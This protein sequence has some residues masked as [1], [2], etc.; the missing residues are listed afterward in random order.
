[1]SDPVDRLRRKYPGISVKSPIQAHALLDEFLPGIDHFS[2]LEHPSAE[3]FRWLGVCH[4][5]VFNDPEAVAAYERAIGLGSQA[6]RINLAHSLG[7]LDRGDEIG[8]QLEQV[9][10]DQLPIY[11]R[12]L[13]LRVK[14]LNDERNGQLLVALKHTEHAW[15]LIQGIPEFSLLA[16]QLLNQLGILH[17]RVGRAQR[18]LWYL[19]RNLELCRG[20]EKT[21]VHL[22]R[23]HVLNSLGLI[24]EARAEFE[25]MEDV[26]EH[27]AP[28]VQLRNAEIAWA[29]GDAKRAMEEYEKTIHLAQQM[30]QSYEEFQASLDLAVLEA[31][32]LDLDPLRRLG[33][34]QQLISD[35]SDRLMYRFRE[36]LVFAWHDRYSPKHAATELAEVASDFGDMGLL[37]EQGWVHVHRAHALREAGD[38]AACSRALDSL[39]VLTSSLQNPAFLAREWG[40]MPEFLSY[41]SRTHPSI[42][43][44]DEAETGPNGPRDAPV[45]PA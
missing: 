17:A 21:R 9:N 18:A 11:D 4:F 12:V 33:R 24:S 42:G 34:A 41:A 35:R 15:R 43:L 37:Q 20:E 31:R 14:S 40:L 38:D 16:P 23:V 39:V 45:T 36:I 22:T 32:F 3:D 26:P 13:Y 29:E 19:D 8:S 28:V 10:F 27:F 1:M 44:G 30:R 7:F 5:S 2:T 25:L 6:A